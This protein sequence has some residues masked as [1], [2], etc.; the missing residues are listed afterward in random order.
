MVG[1]L[2]WDANKKSVEDKAFREKFVMGLIDGKIVI[3]IEE[4]E[5]SNKEK[6]FFGLSL[7]ECAYLEIK[8]I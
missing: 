4:L 1:L 3:N 2:F 5:I 7:I 6:N 8:T